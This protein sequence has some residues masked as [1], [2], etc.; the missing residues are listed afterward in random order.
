MAMTEPTLPDFIQALLAGYV[1]G[2]LT[3]EE[4]EQLQQLL[5]E[6][7]ALAIEIN[8]LQEVLAVMPYG[9]PAA[10]PSAQ[11]RSQMLQAIQNEP[12]NLT[13]LDL[14]NPNLTNP[15]LTNTKPASTA[16]AAPISDRPTNLPTNRPTNRPTNAIVPRR[17]SRFAL[18]AGGSIAAALALAL[19]LNN[20]QLRQ[21]V[22]TMEAQVAHQKDLIAML[23]Q[24]QTRLVAL[25]GM[26]QMAQSSGNAVITPGQAGTVLV[27]QALPAPPAGKSYQ[28]WAIANGKKIAC[29]DFTVTSQ[30]R[31]VIKLPISSTTADQLTGLAITVETSPTPDAPTGPMVMTSVES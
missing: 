15:N 23:Q 31:A 14:T 1:L 3:P 29:G 28:L 18:F 26:D 20:Y 9:L 17:R 10:S 16:S 22:S 7:P 12:L 13:N 4:A 19:G 11:V 8:Q 5:A 24:P 27:L 25:K 30:N 21:Q 2:D 6:N